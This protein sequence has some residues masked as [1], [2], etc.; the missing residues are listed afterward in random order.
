MSSPDRGPVSTRM[1]GRF[2]TPADLRQRLQRLGPAFV[3]IGQFLA[4]RPDLLPQEYCDELLQLTDSADPFPWTAARL[5]IEEDL[6]AA[7]EDRFAWLDQSPL[8]A[9]SLAQVHVGRLLSG[10]E[11][12]VK[13]QRPEIRARIRQ[14]LRRLGWIIRAFEVLGRPLPI[15]RKELSQ[16]IERWLE[17]ELDFCREVR[18]IQRLREAATGRAEFSI[19]RVYPEYSGKRVITEQ[20]LRGVPFSELLR[21]RRLG[22]DEQIESLGFD[23]KKLAENLASTVLRQIFM[24]EVFHADPHPGNLI[25]LPGNVIGFVDFGLVDR[26]DETIRRSQLRYVAAVSGGD[27][28]EILHSVLEVLI[29]TVDSDVETF[30]RSFFVETQRWRREGALLPSGTRRASAF[31]QYMKQLM[32]SARENR[33]LVP[34]SVLSMYRTIVTAESI[35][36]MLS[37]EADIAAMGRRFLDEYRWLSIQRQFS[38]QNLQTVAG[39]LLELTKTMPGQLNRLLSDV[40]EDRLR[41]RVVVTDSPENR[42]AANVRARLVAGAIIFVGIC[43]LS[44]GVPETR[45]L[46]ILNLRFAAVTLLA[47][48]AFGVGILWRSLR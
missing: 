16:E 1:F 6:G 10:E 27:E 29:P 12:V 28:R 20:Y 21:L 47:M 44:V 17:E 42:R 35:A 34:A 11:V 32:Q 39:D 30:R 18:N 46:G 19:P 22:R 24:M 3:K 41:L 13:V 4:L 31:T 15:S 9:A 36:A 26:M 7:I 48:A 23:R 38:L 45:V 43:I 8:A 33:L 40:A 14:D 25:A 2:L 5:M 37:D